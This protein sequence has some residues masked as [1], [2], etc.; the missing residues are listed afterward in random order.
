MTTVLETNDLTRKFGSL[1]AV[2]DVTISFDADEITSIIGPNGA[3][4]T[5][6]YNL[7]TGALKPT[8][9]DV[10]LRT[11]DSGELRSITGKEPYQIAQDGLSRAFQVTNIFEELTVFE[12]IRI[13]RISQQ[14][15]T[16]ELLT[17]TNDDS[18]LDEQV[19]ETIELLK[20]NDVANT[21]CTNL[22]HGDKRK[23]DIAL[24][25]AL[26]PSMMLLDEPTAGM[27]PTETSRMVD[28]I[29]DL[30]NNTETAFAITE[31][32][33]SVIS[34]ISDRILV[35]HEGAIISDGDPEAVLS[36][37]KVKEAYLG[38]VVE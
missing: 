28:I 19:W 32:D 20:L 13:S 9:G 23:V 14:D 7:L 24:A 31:H 5:T 8:T 36:N 35:L 22:S 15:R 18:E 4:K 6:F 25:L 29:K 17:W 26:E 37:Q 1:I 2:D 10:K 30:D 12:N 34:D 16:K 3:G 11:K 27:N 33:M 38:G 21:P